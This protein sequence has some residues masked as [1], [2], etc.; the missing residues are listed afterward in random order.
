MG[1][2]MLPFRPGTW[3]SFDAY[4]DKACRR[5]KY[6]TITILTFCMEPLCAPSIGVERILAE[7]L[8]AVA[9]NLVI[10]GALSLHTTPNQTM[11]YTLKLSLFSDIF[12]QY[13]SRSNYTTNMS[14]I[15]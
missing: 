4:V 9:K 15:I 7:G 13:I 2:K 14:V 6:R 12:F 10:L 11:I 5:P 3:S 8:L 1:N